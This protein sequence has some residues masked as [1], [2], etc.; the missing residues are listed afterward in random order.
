MD[1]LASISY[2]LSIPQKVS[3]KSVVSRLIFV[4]YTFTAMRQKYHNRGQ[5]MVEY[6]LLLA[7]V[8][9]VLLAVIS[10]KGVVTK[11]LENSMN[12]AVRGV[13]CMATKVCYQPGGCPQQYN[14]P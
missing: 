7:V 8:I 13:E 11:S 6:L 4:C 10:P 2:R 1:E 12:L 5:S 3:A 14:C 9:I